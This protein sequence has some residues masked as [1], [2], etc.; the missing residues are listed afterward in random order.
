MLLSLPKQ[1][2]CTPHA[3]SDLRILCRLAAPVKVFVDVRSEEASEPNFQ[4]FECKTQQD[5]HNY[6][7]RQG[8]S[9]LTRAD[10]IHAPVS[11]DAADLEAGCR[12]DLV[13]GRGS[14]WARGDGVADKIALIHEEDVSAAPQPPPR[15]Q[16]QSSHPA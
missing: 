1:A 11:H 5:L 14:E 12:Y 15:A 6:L 9:G 4:E 3:S 10:V 8:A 13:F 7:L 2:L 16:P